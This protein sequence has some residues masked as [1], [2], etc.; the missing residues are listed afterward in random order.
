[1]GGLGETACPTLS[2]YDEPK[3]YF[4]HIGGRGEP[5]KLAVAV[6]GVWDAIKKVRADRPQPATRFPGT[7]PAAGEVSAAPI[8]K[9]LGHR[10]ETQQGVVKMTVGREGSMHGGRGAGSMGLTTWAAFS[11]G[12]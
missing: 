10:A 8:E 4:M 1:A 3:L 9:I 7:V 2:F 6:K 11:G 12:A 5:E